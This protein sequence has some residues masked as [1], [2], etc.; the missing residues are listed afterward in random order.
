[1]KK[2]GFMLNSNQQRIWILD[3]K[4]Q[5]K[6][7][8]RFIKAIAISLITIITKAFPSNGE[9]GFHYQPGTSL[10]SFYGE[11][12]DSNSFSN[13]NPCG[14]LNRFRLAAIIKIIGMPS[15]SKTGQIF[16]YHNKVKIYLQV[17]SGKNYLKVWKDGEPNSG[18]MH[19]F[20][21]G[22]PSKYLLLWYELSATKSEI[23]IRHS[24]TW[25]LEDQRRSTHTLSKN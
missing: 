19:S 18:I 11:Y 23:A 12:Q 2:R 13:T 20:Q 22:A 6:G 1:M 3:Q 14:T 8:N 17:S 10:K 24:Y 4:I 15:S 21:I 25:E 9:C 7:R 5:P 16:S